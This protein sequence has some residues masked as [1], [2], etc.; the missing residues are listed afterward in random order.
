MCVPHCVSHG[1]SLAVSLSAS[2]TAALTV[3]LAGMW[4][5]QEEREPASFAAEHYLLPV[6]SGRY[7]ADTTMWHSPTMN[8]NHSC[9]TDQVLAKC[10][11]SLGSLA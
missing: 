5:T 8:M 3:S 10:A 4:A 1:V 6:S 7:G 9:I 11:P 2:R